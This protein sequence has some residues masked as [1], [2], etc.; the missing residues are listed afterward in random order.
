MESDIFST[1]PDDIFIYFPQKAPLAARDE[2]PQLS[3]LSIFYW[4]RLYVFFHSSQGLLEILVNGM[5][6]E[7]RR[8]FMYFFANVYKAGSPS[9]GCLALSKAFPYTYYA[10]SQLLKTGLHFFHLQKL[11]IVYKYYKIIASV[12]WRDGLAIRTALTC[13]SFCK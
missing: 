5:A 2:A 10:D 4:S 11:F 12:Y 6:S 3:L 1:C 9:P 13:D 8:P 7:N